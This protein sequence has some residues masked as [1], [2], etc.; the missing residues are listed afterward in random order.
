MADSANPGRFRDMAP[1]GDI[2]ETAQPTAESSCLRSAASL[3]DVQATQGQRHGEAQEG[4]QTGMNFGHSGQQPDTRVLLPHLAHL[5][6]QNPGNLCF[7]NAAVYSFLWTTL[8][9]EPCDLR[10]W[11]A[12]RQMLIDLLM[13]HHDSP[14]NLCDERWFQDILGCWGNSDKHTDPSM[15]PQQDAAEFVHVWLNLN[16]LPDQAFHMGWE[17][18]FE[19]NGQAIVFDQGTPTMPICPR[20]DNHLAHAM[21]SLNCSLSGARLMECAQPYWRHHLVFASNWTEACMTLRAT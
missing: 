14:A 6:L 10:H 21:R 15:L 18:R 8:S 13:K 1:H 7:A 12:Q 19:E 11:G 9:M 20:F 3:G 2:H 5:T 16:Q 17:R 4:T